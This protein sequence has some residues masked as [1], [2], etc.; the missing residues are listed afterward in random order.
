MVKKLKRGILVGKRGGPSTPPPTW[1]LEFSADENNNNTTTTNKPVTEFLNFPTKPTVSARK[2]C[3]NLWEVLPHH[4]H[5]NFPLTKKMN[6]GPP[7]PRRQRH[8]NNGSQ[9]PTHLLDPPNSP[10]LHQPIS[11]RCLKRNATASV[12]QRYGLVERNN[13]ALQPLSPASYSSSMEVAPF[14]PALTPTSPLNFKGKKGDQSYSLKTSTELLKVLNRIWSLEEHHASNMSLVKALKMELDHSRAI[15]KELLQEKETDRQ[16]MEDLVKGV[17]EDNLVRKN[18]E[19]D[20]IKAAVQSIQEELEDE[21]KMRKHS[22]SLHRKLAKELSSLK[23]S[24]SSA[25]REL[26]RERKARI[27]LE[28]LC[29]EFAKGIKEYEQEVRSLKHKPE[30]DRSGMEKLDRLVLHISEAWLDERMQM[31]LTGGGDDITE[32]SIIVDKLGFDIE[33]F[34]QA[35]RVVESR[36]NGKLPPNDTK[37]YCSRRHSLESFPLNEASSAPQNAAGEDSTDS[38]SH[39]LEANKKASGKHSTCS[40]AAGGHQ[41]GI[42]K[43]NSMRKKVRPQDITKSCS[44]SSLEAQFEEHLTGTMSCNGNK[45][46]FEDNEGDMEGLEKQEALE[47]LEKSDY[48]VT[49]QQGMQEKHGK[50]VGNHGLKSTYLLENLIRNGS[51]SLE[52]NKIHPESNSREESHHVQSVLTG[53]ASPIQQWKSKLTAPDFK[54]SECSLRWPQELNENTLMAKL[55]E[56]RLEGRKHDRSK[57]SRGSF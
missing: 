39:C 46:Q 34:L 51:L 52:D 55:L 10:P 49:V 15:I 23:S 6:K 5:H 14:K 27:L 33:T 19:Q 13:N 26:E 1:R 57:S 44:H 53:N 48:S 54:K 28:N 12:I 24:F 50:M 22:E 25:L 56:A 35:I 40:D 21:R 17:T 18:K 8:N 29:D 43:S 36:K 2:L 30:K 45:T 4:H 42:V 31:K 38:V 41:D 32:K 9:L 7:R 37:E 3:A 20:R 47:D 11:A 16:E